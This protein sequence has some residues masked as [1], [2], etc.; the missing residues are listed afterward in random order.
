MSRV[1]EWPILFSGQMVRAILEG[2]KTVT[3]RMDRRWLKR[4]PGNRLWVRETWGQLTGYG[5]GP[6]EP[7]FWRADY[8][9]TDLETQHL[10]K[11]RPSIH[12][13]RW[14]SR[15][16]LEVTEE[17]RIEPLS[18]M[19]DGEAKAEGV[20]PFAFPGGMILIGAHLRAF[21]ILWDAINGK[22][23]PWS[24]NPSPVRIAFREIERRA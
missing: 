4:K 2:R 3:R 5:S 6:T 9:S 16:L 13:P 23:Y 15:L 17:P 20:T 1:M 8:S 19:T 12:M 14:A 10:P 22:R 7:V 24:S 11:W 18:D 21:Q